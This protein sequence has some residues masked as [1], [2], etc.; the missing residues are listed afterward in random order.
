MAWSDAYFL[1]VSAHISLKVATKD[2]FRDK[3]TENL[4]FWIATKKVKISLI[5]LE[6]S[7]LVQKHIF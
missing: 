7:C 2:Y 6:W 4:Y 5:N 1:E 3:E